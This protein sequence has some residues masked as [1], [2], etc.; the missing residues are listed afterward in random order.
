M[1]RGPGGGAERLH[2]CQSVSA[3]PCTWARGHGAPVLQGARCPVVPREY[4]PAFWHALVRTPSQSTHPS[5]QSLPNTHTPCHARSG[6]RFEFRVCP[7]STNIDD[8]C[9]GSN[10]LTNAIPGD[11]SFGDRSFWIRAGSVPSGAAR[12][13]GLRFKLPAG[14]SCPGGCVLQW[15][16]VA[17]QSCIERYTPSDRIPPDYATG[18]CGRAG[19]GHASTVGAVRTHAGRQRR[20]PCMPT[21]LIART[22][23]L[24]VQPA[25]AS[26]NG[27]PAA[28]H[29]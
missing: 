26:G 25:C 7:R 4:A 10:Y 6:G 27:V 11:F 13:G 2:H 15:R 8:A 18:V 28:H 19:R 23:E 22:H 5:S 9:L 24:A 16:Y 14:V 17:M 12:F 1:D 20:L 3:Q 29:A 21:S